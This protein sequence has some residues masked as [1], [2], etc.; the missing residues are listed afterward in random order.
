M[1]K[2]TAKRVRYELMRRV[3][4]LR[5]GVRFTHWPRGD[6]RI[7]SHQTDSGSERVLEIRSAAT[8]LRVFVD[9]FVEGQYDLGRFERRADVSARYEAIVASGKVPLIVD[10]GAHNG[11]SALYFRDL[12]P[13]AGILAL[14]P[15]P[16]NFAE[17]EKLMG[18]D[19]LCLCLQAAV[20]SFDGRVM[21]E[22][23]GLGNWGY[24]TRQAEGGVP[25]HR[26]STV[27]AMSPWNAEPFVLKINIEG[28]E[29]DLFEGQAEAL[30]RFYL[31]YVELH[32][33]LFPNRGNS[34]N[35]IKVLASLDRDFL[36]L[37]ENVVSIKNE[38]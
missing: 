37:G 34:R 18:D 8:D 1:L 14:E 20:A 35:V 17:L 32:D 9:V 6:R 3:N 13:K 28:F 21:I 15:E 31:A 24:R 30:D 22:D 25:A 23:P 38:H 33:W 7:V 5:T 2:T 29:R 27:L 16:G 19:S 11:L 4:R 10:A 26:L 36:M 12:Y